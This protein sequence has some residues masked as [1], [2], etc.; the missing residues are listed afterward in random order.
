MWLYQ[1]AWI[2]SCFNSWWNSLATRRALN[3]SIEPSECLLIRKIHLQPTRLEMPSG[4]TS[5][6][7][8]LRTSASIL[9]GHSLTPVMVFE[10]L[11]YRCRSSI[12]GI[13][14]V[15]VKVEFLNRF[16]DV[17]RGSGSHAVLRGRW[18]WDVWFGGWM[19]RWRRWLAGRWSLLWGWVKLESRI[20]TPQPQKDSKILWARA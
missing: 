13:W 12:L 19:G 14:F 10:S 2:V 4:G 8:P 5:S 20:A 11:W 15:G 3:L 1:A 9:F 6:Q 16:G 17:I 18:N 7:V